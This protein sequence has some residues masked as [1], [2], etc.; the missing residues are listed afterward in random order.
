MR[1]IAANTPIIANKTSKPGVGAG[2]ADGGGGDVGR[3]VGV[4]V[5]EG[6]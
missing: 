3:G 4:A 6:V 5:G 2:V 1:Y